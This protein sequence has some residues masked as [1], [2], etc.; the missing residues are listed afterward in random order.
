MAV[1]AQA[2]RE[3]AREQR[4]CAVTG[5]GGR[6]YHAHHAVRVQDVRAHG[7]DPHDPRNAL[8]LAAQAHLDHHSGA[9][10]IALTALTDQNIEYAFELMGP[11]AFDYLRRHYDGEDPRLIERLQ[12]DTT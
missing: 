8:R 2:F 4:V 7:G 6:A 12:T 1:S 5:Q 11:R 10:R 9:H 3:A